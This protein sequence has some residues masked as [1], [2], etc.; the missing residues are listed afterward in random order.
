VEFLHRLPWLTLEVAASC[1]VPLTLSS[2]GQRVF[3]YQPFCVNV[4][5]HYVLFV[6]GWVRWL[7]D[8]S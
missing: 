2:H 7:Y 4:M 1:Q 5:A 3:L 8:P 6:H